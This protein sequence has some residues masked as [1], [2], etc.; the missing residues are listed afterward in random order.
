[1]QRKDWKFTYTG[2]QLAEA[3]QA[4]I[5]FH[6]ERFGFWKQR[7][8]E[9]VTTIRSEGLEIEEKT[10]IGYRNPKAQDWNRGTQV[11]VR[12]DLQLNLDEAQEKLAWHTDK[13]AEYEGWYQVLIA[14]PNASQSLDIDDWL[15]FFSKQ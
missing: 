12:N 13:L 11:L 14:N 1:M 10:S 6:K 9:V 2:K 15:F 7:R 4:K 3:V 8:E 5:T